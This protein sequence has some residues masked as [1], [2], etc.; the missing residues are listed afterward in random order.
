MNA[1]KEIWEWLQT[2]S[3]HDVTSKLELKIYAAI[4]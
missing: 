4:T 2:V 3:S 1:L